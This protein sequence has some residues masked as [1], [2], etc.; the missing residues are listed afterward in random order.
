MGYA[1]ASPRSKRQPGTGIG[2]RRY[3]DLGSGAEMP[4]FR[5]S[6]RLI[7]RLMPRVLGADKALLPAALCC[8]LMC[9]DGAAAA[10]R[11][12]LDPLGAEELL[13][14]RDVLA[15]AGGFSH[16]TKFAWIGLEE[17]PKAL[18]QGFEPGRAF[19]RR[20]RLVA[21]DFG[22]RKNFAVTVDVGAGRLDA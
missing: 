6:F 4:F 17:P 19:A 7:R 5:E 13:V 8:V 22:R 9:L 1:R 3:P 15:H 21:L 11:H 14:I 16:D 20:A 12:P 2:F 18:V 10:A